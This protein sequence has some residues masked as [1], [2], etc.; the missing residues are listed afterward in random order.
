MRVKGLKMKKLWHPEHFCVTF[1]Y[2]KKNKTKQTNKLKYKLRRERLT[3]INEKGA[4]TTHA[5]IY[6]T[7]CF[8][9]VFTPTQKRNVKD[10]LLE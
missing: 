4:V 6:V 9:F 8:A 2:K 7:F 1:R 3:K 10:Y 5:S